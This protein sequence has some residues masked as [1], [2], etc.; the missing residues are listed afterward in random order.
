[1]ALK[2]VV[3]HAFGDRQIGDEITDPNEVSDVIASHRHAVVPVTTDDAAQP[4]LKI[5]EKPPE[6]D[7]PPASGKDDPKS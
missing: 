4:P 7:P 5:A 1:M 6:A 3:T 2:L